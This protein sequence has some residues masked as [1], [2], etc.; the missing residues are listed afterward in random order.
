MT[1]ETNQPPPAPPSG[2]TD[3]AFG[4]LLHVTSLPSP[5]GVDRLARAGQ[6]WWQVLPLGP[7]G[8]GDSPYQPLSSF[9][10]NALLVSP[11]LLMRDG[12]LKPGDFDEATF[13][14]GPVD[15]P[16]VIRFKHGLLGRAWSHY[17]AGARPDLRPAFE[18]FRDEQA[19]WLDDHALFRALKARHN[20]AYYLEWSSPASAAA[21]R[22]PLAAPPSASPPAPPAGSP[23]RP[24]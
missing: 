20:G 17:R 16:A 9:A 15:Y 11:D 14:A 10:G 6:S 8:L 13:P 24:G 22:T 5:F 2:P 12:L 21:P 18:R 23:P 4:V 3:C 7:T 1:V 19:H